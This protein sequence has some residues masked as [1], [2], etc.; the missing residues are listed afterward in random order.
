MRVA[1]VERPPRFSSPHQ[2]VHPDAIA[3]IVWA[4]HG[5]GKVFS[6]GR[7]ARA[8]VAAGLSRLGNLLAAPVQPLELIAA[9]PET[10][11]VDQK[12]GIGG[13]DRLLADAVIR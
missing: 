13:G 9:C 11:R 4:E 8:A 3:G 12:T 10:T 5:H 7:N 6:V 1:R 2:V